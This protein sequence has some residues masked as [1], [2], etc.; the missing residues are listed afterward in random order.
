LE[1][2]APCSG[3]ILALRARDAFR[4]DVLRGSVRYRR[5][6]WPGIRYALASELLAVGGGAR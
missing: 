4:L 6:R 2:Y 1:R 5:T 3:I